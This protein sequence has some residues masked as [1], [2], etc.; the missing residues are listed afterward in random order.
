MGA[1][2]LPGVT[3]GRGAVVG[4][5]AVVTKSVGPLE[6]VGGNPA[7]LIGQRGESDFCYRP[8]ESSALFEAWLGPIATRPAPQ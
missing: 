7:G 1:T 4:A 8:S 5:G 3:I 6:I 2:L